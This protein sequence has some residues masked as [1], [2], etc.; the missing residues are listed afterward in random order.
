MDGV[1][2]AG[3]GSPAPIL[4]ILRNIKTRGPGREFPNR[5]HFQILISIK[6]EVKAFAEKKDGVEKLM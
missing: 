6:P 4:F 3:K 2:G 5:T 1:G